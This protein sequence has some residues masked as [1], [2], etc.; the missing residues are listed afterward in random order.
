[1]MHRPEVQLA[2]Y[3]GRGIDIGQ[4]VCNDGRKADTERKSEAGFPVTMRFGGEF[5]GSGHHFSQFLCRPQP[6]DCLT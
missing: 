6:G 5:W 3:Q 2:K 4:K 1:M